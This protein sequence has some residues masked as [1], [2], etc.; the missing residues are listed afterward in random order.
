[1]SE[2]VDDKSI[3]EVDNISVGKY[4]STGYD[5][6]KYFRSSDCERFMNFV[7]EEA[8]KYF[9]ENGYSPIVENGKKD[10]VSYGID[11]F[12][13]VKCL[14]KFIEFNVKEGEDLKELV[15]L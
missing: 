14:A 9:K 4:I 3:A 5:I 2:E 7:V 8:I 13:L 15:R 6:V 11:Y 12:F 1:M 10:F